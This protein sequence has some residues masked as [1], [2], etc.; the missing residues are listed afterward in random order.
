MHG[1]VHAEA[2]GAPRRAVP[3]RDAIDGSRAC[4]S[5]V[6]GGVQH[7]AGTVIVDRK[8]ED[9]AFEAG[10]RAEGRQPLFV[11]A[12]RLLEKRHHAHIRD[13]VVDDRAHDRA[14][15]VDPVLDRNRGRHG[16]FGDTLW[17]LAQER[18]FAVRT[19][20][21][22]PT[23][24]G[25]DTGVD[26][27][28]II[29]ADGAHDAREVARQRARAPGVQELCEVEAAN[30]AVAI[31]VRSA[32]AAPLREQQREVGGVDL[33]VGREI[34]RAAEA[35]LRTRGCG[36]PEHREKHEQRGNDED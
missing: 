3:A 33:R 32:G 20:G 14:S 6:A 11:E 17:K 2:D 35:R 29:E 27:R 7:R 13:A 4:E 21:A 9:G 18:E 34:G 26:G 5:E 15:C 30:G 36:E 31:D 24:I 22:R 12:A 25:G 1:A 28:A 8:R 16:E 23:E 10:H 19:C